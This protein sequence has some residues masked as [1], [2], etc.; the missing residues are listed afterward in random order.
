MHEGLVEHTLTNFKRH[1]GAMFLPASRSVLASAAVAIAVVA[2]TY[3]SRAIIS[4]PS[5]SRRFDIVVFGATGYTGS[6]ASEYL[7]SR[8]GVKFS[9]CNTAQSASSIRWALAGR[10]LSKLEA[11]RKRIGAPDAGNFIV[12]DATSDEDMRHLARST[13]AVVSFA[14][15][16]Q[17]YGSKLVAACAAEG[18]D[19]VP[20]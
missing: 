6:I 13:R 8:C 9:K 3:V 17:L 15:P 20:S 4:Q 12:A 5:V 10:K 7:M 1:D 14:G 2:I 18:T 16:Y 19:C 11:L